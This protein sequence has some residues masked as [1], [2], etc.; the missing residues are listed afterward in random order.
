MSI[1][2]QRSILYWFISNIL[3]IG[4][5]IYG[6]QECPCICV[7]FNQHS[8]YIETKLYS[9]LDYTEF[10]IVKKGFETDEKRR[11][12]V[13]D[14]FSNRRDTYPSFIVNYSS[15]EPAKKAQNMDIVGCSEVVTL[16]DFRKG[17]L[18]F[19]EVYFV[20]ES[21]NGSYIVWK[22]QLWAEE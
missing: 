1:I 16:D 15:H 19:Y 18:F 5:F 20:K 6:S 13:N 17:G 3:I 12:A 9:D 14:Y 4:I 10:T 11:E 22:A 2:V 8:E 21:Q 7:V